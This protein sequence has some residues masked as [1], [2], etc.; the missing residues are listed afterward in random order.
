MRDDLEKDVDDC[1]LHRMEGN[2]SA[3][4]RWMYI[5]L[6]RSYVLSVDL[7]TT[8][9]LAFSSRSNNST[10]QLTNLHGKM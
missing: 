8:H 5:L 2:E 7:D 3:Q 9:E 10:V 6:D 4:L 1:G